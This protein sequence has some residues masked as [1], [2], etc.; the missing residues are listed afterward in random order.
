M[1]QWG[2]AGYLSCMANTRLYNLG[3]LSSTAN[4]DD[5]KKATDVSHEVIERKDKVK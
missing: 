4:G 2:Q 3:N 1:K 5:S